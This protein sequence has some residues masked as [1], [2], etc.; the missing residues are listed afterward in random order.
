MSVR[1]REQSV[2][3]LRAQNMGVLMAE[4][5]LQNPKGLF[6]PSPYLTHDLTRIDPPAIREAYDKDF[7]NDFW[8]AN[9]NC[10]YVLFDRYL[11]REQKRLQVMAM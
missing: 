4:Y 7:M 10:R 9:Y 5:T 8:S 2:L 3:H 11:Q 6:Y 1:S